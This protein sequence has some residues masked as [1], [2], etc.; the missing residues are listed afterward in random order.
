MNGGGQ[1]NVVRWP[2]RGPI[3][4]S[5]PGLAPGN[6]VNT[7]GWLEGVGLFAVGKPPT[8]PLDPV[9]APIVQISQ[10]VLLGEL[11]MANRM[12]G[13]LLRFFSGLIVGIF[14]R[15]LIGFAPVLAL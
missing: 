14:W 7:A 1:G 2:S 12:R 8:P 6:A 4:C 5:L 11:S 15:T 3:P 9:A 13:M 10:L